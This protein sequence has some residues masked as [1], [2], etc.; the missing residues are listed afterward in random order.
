MKKWLPLIITAV[1]AI[2]ALGDLRPA[3]V[4]DFDWEKFGSIPV[5]ANGRF[6][7]L[8]SL[9]RN[10]LL[11]L[12]EKSTG[13]DSAAPNVSDKKRQIPASRWTGAL[14]VAFTVTQVLP[15]S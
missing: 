2:Y 1:F 6:Q 7:P 13:L 9:A 10:T 8:D 11:Q 15:P 5:M 14:G 4:K 12:R 3:K